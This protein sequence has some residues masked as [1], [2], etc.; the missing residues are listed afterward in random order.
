VECT[1]IL[2]A[3]SAALKQ[4]YNQPLTILKLKPCTYKFTFHTWKG[5]CFNSIK[6]TSCMA[7]DHNSVVL[8]RVDFRMWLIVFKCTSGVTH[9]QTAEIKDVELG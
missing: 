1:Y 5:R 4:E 9:H 8:L 3:E 6:C 2:L 7:V